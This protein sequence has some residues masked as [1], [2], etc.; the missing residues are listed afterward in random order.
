MTDAVARRCY[1][2][3]RSPVEIKQMAQEDLGAHLDHARAKNGAKGAAER[4]VD[5]HNICGGASNVDGE[6]PMAV[7]DKLV[8]Q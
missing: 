8:K 5:D 3:D 1:A 2:G 6:V 7:V 4:W